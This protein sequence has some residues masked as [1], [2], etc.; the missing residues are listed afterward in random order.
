MAAKVKV[1]IV[2]P[3]DGERLINTRLIRGTLKD[4]EQKLR[5]E[6]SIE[7]C[8]AE[9]AHELADVEIEACES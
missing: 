3:A 4:V 8:S 1:Y 6:V 9:Q 5:A 2:K 7:P